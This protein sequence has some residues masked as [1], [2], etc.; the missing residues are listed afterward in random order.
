MNN[1]MTASRLLLV[2][3]HQSIVKAPDA[4][5]PTQLRKQPHTDQICIT[6]YSHGDPVILQWQPHVVTVSCRS[7]FHVNSQPQETIVFGVRRCRGY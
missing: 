6:V 5:V 2:C 3:G 1:V 7:L 4:D